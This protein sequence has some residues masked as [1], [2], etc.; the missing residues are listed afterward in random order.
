MAEREVYEV[1]AVKYA[2]NATRK[3]SQNLIFN[4]LHDS[5][6]P[7]DYFVWVVRGA[8]RT[9]VVDTGFGERESKARGVP[10]IR[11]PAEG[12]RLLGIDAAEVEDVII[13]H[14]HY[15][16]AGGQ[17]QHAQRQQPEP[18]GP[19]QVPDGRAVAGRHQLDGINA[20]A[21]L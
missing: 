10:L 3:A 13:T 15:D 8:G 18:D 11:T 2:H 5:P 20:Q 17:H 7:L 6:M 4:D 12:L 14:L 9:F 16:H 19:Q 21:S 1:F